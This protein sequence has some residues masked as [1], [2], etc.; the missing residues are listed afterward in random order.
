MTCSTKDSPKKLKFGKIPEK[1]DFSVFSLTKPACDT[2]ALAYY[3][4]FSGLVPVLK[5]MDI[6]VLYLNFQS[7][8]IL[9]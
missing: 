8:F 4:S 1:N 2:N 7:K 5:K 9:K 6:F 3:V